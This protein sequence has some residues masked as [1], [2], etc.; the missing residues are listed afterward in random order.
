MRASAVSLTFGVSGVELP[1]PEVL[2]PALL[3]SARLLPAFL[4]FSFLLRLLSAPV[5]PALE[6]SRCLPPWA[7]AY[8]LSL[9]TA[10]VRDLLPLALSPAWLLDLLLSAFLPALPLAPVL[11]ALEPSRCLPPW[12]SAYTLSLTTA[13]SSGFLRS[14]IFFRPM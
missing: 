5:L 8:T 13:S 7:T 12:A 4:P 9:T 6:P 1:L 10:F 2:L 11:P 14:L 3:L